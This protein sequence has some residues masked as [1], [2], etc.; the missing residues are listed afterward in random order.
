[1]VGWTE[2]RRRVSHVDSLSPREELQSHQFGTEPAVM[3]KTRLH[4]RDFIQLEPNKDIF[5]KIYRISTF[6]FEPSTCLRRFPLHFL[7]LSQTNRIR[8]QRSR[9]SYWGDTSLFLR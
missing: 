7:S 2:R 8:F 4:H 3:L 6:N 5:V 9:H 1:M